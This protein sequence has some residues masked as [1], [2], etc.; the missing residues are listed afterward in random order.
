MRFWVCWPTESGKETWYIENTRRKWFVWVGGRKN[1]IAIQCDTMQLKW[2]TNLL[3][4]RFFW[5]QNKIHIVSLFS[6]DVRMENSVLV[7]L[8]TNKKTKIT[9]QISVH[10]KKIIVNILWFSSIYILFCSHILPHFHLAYI[11]RW[12]FTSWRKSKLRIKKHTQTQNLWL[13]SVWNKMK[14]ERTMAEMRLTVTPLQRHFDI[15]HLLICALPIQQTEFHKHTVEMRECNDIGFRF[16]RSNYSRFFAH[17]HPRI[18]ERK[19]YFRIRSLEL[20]SHS[21]APNRLSI[22]LFDLSLH[23]IDCTNNDDDH[24]DKK[25]TRKHFISMNTNIGFL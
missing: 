17:S 22:S 15:K 6:M 12:C 2:K 20:L 21:L 19:R 5:W 4:Y 7:M 9:E 16:H 24:D 3:S 11:Y 23:C 14:T 8:F 25:I 1:K 18:T 10:E 13:L